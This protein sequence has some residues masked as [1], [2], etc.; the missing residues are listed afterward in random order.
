MWPMLASTV[1]LP[2]RN[3]D[4]V[5]AFAGDSTMTRALP[6]KAFATRFAICVNCPR[7]S[8]QS[9]GVRQTL[10]TIYLGFGGPHVNCRKGRAMTVAGHAIAMALPNIRP[11]VES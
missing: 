10:R 4:I 11:S 9:Y 7:A 1:Y 6:V 5:L 3:L 2:P 8:H